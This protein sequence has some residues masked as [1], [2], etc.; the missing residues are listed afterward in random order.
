[1]LRIRHEDLDS[2]KVVLHLDGSVVAEWAD[3]LER[4]CADAGRPGRRVVVDLAGVVFIGRSG[5]QALGRLS[6]S[7]VG[8]TGASPLIAD[9]LES[10]G[11]ELEP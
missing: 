3:L 4:V 5:F 2:E 11:I 1:M 6:R 7:G 8:I 9:M 10:D